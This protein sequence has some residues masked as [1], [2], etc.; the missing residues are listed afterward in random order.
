[1]LWLV[2][3]LLA[4]FVTITAC[5]RLCLAAARSSAFEKHVAR[6]HELTLHE[7]AF[8]AGGPQRVVDLTLVSMARERRLLLAHTGWVTVVDPDGRDDVERSVIGAIGSYGQS[9]TAPVR[10]ATAAADAVRGI[11][12]RLVA[13]GLAVPLGSRTSLASA[14]R[15]VRVAAAVVFVLGALAL[16]IPGATK[17][18]A[19]PVLAWFL[20][21]FFLALCGLLTARMENH[22]SSRWASPAGQ[23]VL[24]AAVGRVDPGDEHAALVSVALHGVRAIDEPDLRAALTHRGRDGNKFGLT[25]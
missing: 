10:A 4:W 22:A 1:M 23:R 9:R 13:K 17:G 6:R 5:V 14:V 12:D 8:L 21:P 19:G 7:A 11:A 3:L 24:E 18:A 15:Q 2:L 20:L 16:L 25:L